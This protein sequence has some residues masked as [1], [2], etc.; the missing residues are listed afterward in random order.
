MEINK[1]HILVVDDDIK[2]KE[3]IKQF[4]TEK[5]FI[6]STASN[7]EEAKQKIEFFD[8]NLIVLDVMMPGQDGY[9]LTKEIKKKMNI[10]IIL[11]TAKGEV[12]NR[13]KG[14]ELGDTSLG[15]AYIKYIPGLELGLD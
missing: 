4:L 9:D 15:I 6:V 14:L 12:E 8:F 1:I 3:L 7:A 11:L 13:I 10:P 5:G 2:I